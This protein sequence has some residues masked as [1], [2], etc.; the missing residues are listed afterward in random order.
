MWSRN[1]ARLEVSREAAQAFFEDRDIDPPDELVPVIDIENENARAG[2]A[3]LLSPIRHAEVEVAFGR[4]LAK[5]ERDDGEKQRKKREMS[6]MN[7][8][9]RAR[10]QKQSRRLPE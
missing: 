3:L 5:G 7:C 8:D 2:T 10:L 9:S 1:A 6:F 4:R